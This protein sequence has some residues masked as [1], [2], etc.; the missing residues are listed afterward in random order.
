MTMY[1][2]FY[3]GICHVIADYVK[4]G[5][6]MFCWLPLTAHGDNGEAEKMF[7]R[8][9]DILWKAGAS[10]P[11]LASTYNNLGSLLTGMCIVV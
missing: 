4:K 11:A 7:R 9:I 1:F 10:T 8:A 3:Y 6:D 5:V 2:T